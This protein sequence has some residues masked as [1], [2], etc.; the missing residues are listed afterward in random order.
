MKVFELLR[1]LV[2]ATAF[3][4]FVCG[5]GLCVSARKMRA[6]YFLAVALLVTSL[7]FWRAVFWQES[8]FPLYGIVLGARST[9][10][11]AL[12][13]MFFTLFPLEYILPGWLNARR[14]TKFLLPF[15]VCVA[16]YVMCRLCG[17]EF[18]T[19][20]SLHGLAEHV[21]EFNVWVRIP[22]FLVS[23]WYALMIFWIPYRV[24]R[25][26]K[27]KK[28]IMTYSFC[29][30]GVTAVYACVVLVGSVWS[31]LVYMLYLLLFSLMITCQLLLHRRLGKHSFR[32]RFR[33]KALFRE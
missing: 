6:Q 16:V 24:N 7:F 10:S 27:L 4:P 22:F 14:T 13:A 2:Y 28:W 23:L 33:E 26:M 17:V 30:L 15:L 9:L 29:S 32:R 18:R 11:G 12:L 21:T 5:V 20:A 1:I 3:L 25:I 8:V 31:I 19:L